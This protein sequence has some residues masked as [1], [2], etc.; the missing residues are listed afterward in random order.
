MSDKV[1]ITQP[2]IVETPVL[3]YVAGPY[4]AKTAWEV[5]KNIQNARSWGAV[6]AKAGAYPVIPHSN[7]A[8][9]DGVAPD[10]LWLA[11]TMEMLR[12][13]DGAVFIA[14]WERSKGAQAE[15]EEAKRLGLPI[16]DV[17]VWKARTEA[18]VAYDLGNWLKF[19]AQARDAKLKSK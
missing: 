2:P 19:V 1:Y 16:L 17:S 12:R 11:G 13:C 8:H 10:E 15:L 4:R 9:M 18:I 5:D 6:L 7:T 14:G 3:V